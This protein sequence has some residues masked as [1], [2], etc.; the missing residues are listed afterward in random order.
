[1]DERAQAA[2]PEETSSGNGNGNGAVRELPIEGVEIDAERNELIVLTL[3][4][5]H[6]YAGLP[7]VS[8]ATRYESVAR[9]LITGLTD[10]AEMRQLTRRFE[11]E[12]LDRGIDKVDIT[13]LPEEEISIQVDSAR[14]EEL[15]LGLDGV[16][17]RVRAFSRDL[18]NGRRRRR[19]LG[20][21]RARHG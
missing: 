15:G 21:H 20:R 10:P 2:P 9:V 13:G 14:L 1:M 17:E 8:L 19:W 5:G 4:P 7:Q 6:F 12:L 3:D 16:G 11:N 18:A